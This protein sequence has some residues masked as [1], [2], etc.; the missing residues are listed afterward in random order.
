MNTGYMGQI[1]RV[2]LSAGSCKIEAIDEIKARKFVGGVGYAAEI[3]FNELKPG[4]DPL[5][6]ENKI[7][8]ATS[9]LSDNL[10]PGGGSV[11]IC[12]KSPLSK[13]WGESRSGGNFGPDLRRA[14]F[15]M[16]IFEG[17]SEK[18][19]YLEVLDGKASL[20]DA[21]WLVGK[22]IYQKTDLIE[23]KMPPDRK[24]KSVMCIGPAGENLVSFASIMCRDRAA[25]RSGGGAVMGSKNILAI[26]VSGSSKVNHADP[27]AF[28]KAVKDAM[29][30]VKSHEVRDWFNEY[31]TTGDLAGAD[32]S[33]DLPT[34]N[35]RANNWGSGTELFEHFQEKN[36]IRPNQC[37]SGCPI[38]C[39]RICQVKEGPYKTPEHEGGEYETVAAFTAFSL[40][41]N[42]DAAVHCSYLC[43]KWGM[44]TIT[45]GSMISFAMDCYQEGIL[46][47]EK[48]DGMDLSWGNTSVLPPLLEKM[49]FRQGIGD[50]LADGVR[51]AAKKIGNGADKLAIHVKGLEGPAH[52][53][54]SGKTLGI[55]YGTANRG[56]CHIH[57]LE[58]MSYDKGKQ[59]WG[60]LKYGVRDPEQ[61]DQWD[62]KGK[63]KDCALL[64]RGL[65]LPDI[66][67]TCK[68]MCY[69]G[70]TP[71]HWA[72]MLSATT[73][74]DIDG[75]ELIRV[76]ERVINLQRMF[77]VRESLN[78]ND[79][80][81]P[82][83]LLSMPEFGAFKDK[84]EC[85]IKDYHEMLDEYYE[86]CGWD[87]K[88]GVPTEDKLRELDLNS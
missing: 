24:H 6:P 84:K 27:K 3:L 52:D 4:V 50:I 47:K 67:S 17:K 46:T 7:I 26:A 43:N 33:G 63:G 80:M 14:G 51:E 13:T 66:L 70:I 1:L 8:F 29:Q 87:I 49:A 19:V 75:Q 71:D 35:W 37:Y 28:M 5:G 39:G 72:S 21:S 20:K 81:L 2:D 41:K 9:P 74:W 65:I 15:D 60:M 56:M 62:E 11:S 68:F 86:A 53:P 12:F 77:N 25:G 10:V 83:R 36:L 69:A 73:G 48:A 18:P 30:T 59:D 55:A 23:E 64:Q 22:N 88:T 79:D 58:G 45:A 61:I 40:N 76:G 57:P 44:D 85:I 78:R 38:G 82:K 54:R 42:M 31:G 16:L 34:K 32:E